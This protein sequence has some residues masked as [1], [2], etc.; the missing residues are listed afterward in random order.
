[1]SLLNN[2]FLFLLLFTFIKPQYLDMS[3]EMQKPFINYIDYCRRG[4][5]FPNRKLKYL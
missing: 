1:M 4:V 5:L 2:L 3:E